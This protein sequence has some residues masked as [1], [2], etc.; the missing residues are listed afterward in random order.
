MDRPRDVLDR[1]AR[2]ANPWERRTAILATMAFIRR[3]E[4]DD[5][6]RIAEALVADPHDLVQKGGGL[7]AARAPATS[8]GRG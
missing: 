8:T 1:L 4:L 7:G 2:S 6:F 3:G 5:T